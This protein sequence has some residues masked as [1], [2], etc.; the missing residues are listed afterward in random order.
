MDARI[1]E[2]VARLTAL[3]R[4]RAEI[5]AEIDTLQ[6]PRSGK[7]AAIKVVP[8]A[9]AGDP[10]DRNSAIEKRL[11]C[12]AGFSVAA[13]MSSPSVGRI[14]L[15]AA[16]ATH[17]PV[18][19][20]GGV[21]FAKN[22]KSNARHVQIRHSAPSMMCQ[23]NGIYAGSTRMAPHSLWASIRCLRTIPVRS[24]RR[25]STKENG[26]EMSPLLGRPAGATKFLLPLSSRDPEMVLTLGFFSRSRYRRRRRAVS[27][28]SLS[29]TRWNVSPTSDSDPTIGFSRARIQ[30]RRVGSE[31]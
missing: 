25:I 6:S 27:G 23:S 16:A 11:L 8:S 18:R 14:A 5:V 3:E 17:L 24:W 22:Q 12:F 4:E 28:H 2:L 29:P 20:N 15:R 31:I 13:Q 21:G 9:I 10:I 19:M 30:C 7:T 1:A 26:G